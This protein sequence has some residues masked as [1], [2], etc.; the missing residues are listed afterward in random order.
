LL[1]ASNHSFRLYGMD[2]DGML[3]QATLVNGYLYSPWLVRPLTWLTPLQNSPEQSAAVSE[4][5]A[6]S[7]PPHLAETLAETEHDTE[8]QWRFEPIKKRRKRKN[9]GAEP[10]IK[11]GLLF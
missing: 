7:A 9:A 8:E 2:I 6:A 1:H 3:C 4:V 5:M 10:E 11:Q